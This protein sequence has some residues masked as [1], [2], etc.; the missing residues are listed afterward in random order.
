[1]SLHIVKDVFYCC[2]LIRGFFVGK[3]GLEFTK[4]TVRW[5]ESHC[6]LNV[7][8]GIDVQEFLCNFLDRV[9]N[10]FSRG[11]PTLSPQFVYSRLVALDADVFLH[12]IQPVNGKIKEVSVL[13][14]Q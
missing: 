3:G 6:L 12:P 11:G 9:L 1:M 4:R 14:F 7:T 5:R 13:V 2:L 10:S 8:Q